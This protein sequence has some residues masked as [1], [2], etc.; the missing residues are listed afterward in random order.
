MGVPSGRATGLNLHQ[1]ERRSHAG[2]LEVTDITDDVAAAV[3]ASGIRSGIACV[4]SPGTTSCVRVNEFETG[5][6][7]DFAAVLGRLFGWEAGA[8][9]DGATR[10]VSM[11]LGPAGESVPVREGELLLGRWQRVLFLELDGEQEASWLV[12]VVGNEW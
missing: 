5:L 2:A 1:Q 4:Y 7:E 11:L 10:S 9:S 6:L 3:R 12:E 8:G